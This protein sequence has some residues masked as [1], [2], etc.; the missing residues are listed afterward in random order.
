MDK[1]RELIGHVPQVELEDGPR[2][3]TSSGT[4]SSSPTAPTLSRREVTC[5]RT[6]GWRERL[7]RPA[8]T[9]EAGDDP[10]GAAAGARLLPGEGAAADD[11]APRSALEAAGFR[12]VDVNLTLRRAPA[13][14][15]AGGSTVGDARAGAPDAVLEIAARHFG[16]LALSPRPAIPDAVAGARS[17]ATGRRPCWTASAASAARGARRRRRPVGFLARAARGDAAVI[18]LIAVAPTRRGARARAARSSRAWPRARDRRRGRAPRS[19]TPARCAST[20]GSASD[21][22]DRATSCTSTRMR[23]GP[24][25]HR[26]SGSRVVAEIGNNHEGDVGVARELVERAAD[27]G[28]HAVKLQTI[29]P[30]ALVAPT[31]RERSPSSSASGSARR[32]TP[33]SPTLA[34]ERG[35]GFVSTPFDLDSADLLAPLVDALQDRVGRQ[36]LRPR[37]FEA[38]PRP[39]S[40]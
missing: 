18:D 17:S 3:A 35:L 2:G 40:R 39:A 30:A 38:R 36:R 10:R 12:V 4:A 15:R 37:C 8:F 34:R 27:A 28:A 22:R 33:S 29:D 16:A 13:P 7:G 19:R 14:L 20:S 26:A 31:S 32:V 9:V 11:V 1:A 23:I 6:P 24:R 5:A 25:R 21:R